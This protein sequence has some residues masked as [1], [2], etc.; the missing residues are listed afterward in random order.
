[1][2]VVLYNDKH[3]GVRVLMASAPRQA[4]DLVE[5]WNG[6]DEL[7]KPLPRASTRGR[8]C[9][10]SRSPRSTCCPSTTPANHAYKNDENTGGWGGD[11]G[12]PFSVCAAGDD[13]VLAWDGNEAGW[14]LIRTD[15]EGKK[16]WGIINS[17]GCLAT[18]GS[19]SSPTRASSAP[20]C[21]ASMSRMADRS[22]GPPA[23]P[24]FR[25]RPRARRNC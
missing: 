8:V 19:R 21:A 14:G 18:D 9:T 22:P 1:V 7:G 25:N 5:K 20:G 11:H 24:S 16:R 4:G 3:E 23:P 17:Q 12:R 6:L 2:S 10:I 13:M 15:G